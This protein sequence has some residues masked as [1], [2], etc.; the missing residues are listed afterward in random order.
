VFLFEQF[1]FTRH[2]DGCVGPLRKMV[3]SMG[4]EAWQEHAACLGF[5]HLPWEGH[6]LDFIRRCL[7]GLP[8]DL[9]LRAWGGSSPLLAGPAPVL[10]RQVD[11]AHQPSPCV[12]FWLSHSKYFCMRASV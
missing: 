2:V 3:N 4:E 5:A 8:P 9:H 7:H 6:T 10:C 1:M 12:P 11:G